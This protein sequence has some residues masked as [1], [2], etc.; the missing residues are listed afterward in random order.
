L[1]DMKMGN[2][3]RSLLATQKIPT[4]KIVDPLIA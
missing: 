4:I 3:F 2:L 1:Y